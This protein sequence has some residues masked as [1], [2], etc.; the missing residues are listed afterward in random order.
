[1]IIPETNKNF[2]SRKLVRSEKK[3]NYTIDA[4]STR[5]TIGYS[6]SIKARGWRSKN[7]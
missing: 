3:N 7:K 2:R 1:M 6:R 4:K 5:E